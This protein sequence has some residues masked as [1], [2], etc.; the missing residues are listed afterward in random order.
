LF[1][2]NI[3][4]FSICISWADVFFPLH[5]SLNFCAHTRRAGCFFGG[6]FAFFCVWC[7]WAAQVLCVVFRSGVGPICGGVC[8]LGWVLV[9]VFLPLALLRL[10]WRPSGLWYRLLFQKKI[11]LY[12]FV[13]LY[14]WFMNDA[15]VQRI[16]FVTY[17][18]FD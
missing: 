4:L 2:N 1:A 17:T 13:V 11:L 9:W 5:R 16:K 7:A 15:A 14:V 12:I 3:I 6:F 10:V 18:T 8:G